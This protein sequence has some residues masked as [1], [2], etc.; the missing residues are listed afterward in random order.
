MFNI[1]NVK[2]GDYVETIC[3]DIG[4]INRAAIRSRSASSGKISIIVFEW[5]SNGKKYLCMGDNKSL[6]IF[7]Q[8][9]TYVFDDKENK[10]NPLTPKAIYKDVKCKKIEIKAEDYPSDICINSIPYS[11]ESILD[12]IEY[13]NMAM[14]IKIN[15]IIKWINERG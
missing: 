10:I 1:N 2:A 7:K 4:Y 15:E 14:G 5:I 11:Y 6:S 13:D 3:G 8:I 9:G 12:H